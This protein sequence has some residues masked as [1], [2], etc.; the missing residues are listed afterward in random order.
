MTQKKLI[1]VLFAL[2][3]VMFPMV[4]SGC[5]STDEESMVEADNLGPAGE[6]EIP[7]PN[8]PTAIW[9]PGYWAPSENDTFAWIPGQVVERP[10]PTAVWNS[11]RWV[12]HNYGWSFQ[13]GHW[14]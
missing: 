6:P 2:A 10:S 1:Q 8:T 4:L 14:Q 7:P 3:T 12:K 9:I 5:A 13:D 11:A